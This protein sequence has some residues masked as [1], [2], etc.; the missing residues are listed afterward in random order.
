MI[1]KLTFILFFICSFAQSQMLIDIHKFAAA[2]NPELYTVGNAIATGANEANGITGLSFYQTTGQA[3]VS[4]SP[5]PQDGS[6]VL[7]FSETSAPDFAYENLTLD[8]ST[9]YEIGYWAWSDTS[10]GGRSQIWEGFT[11][12]PDFYYTTTPTYYE[13]TLTTNASSQILRWY[14]TITSAWV[15]IDGLSIKEQ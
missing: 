13:H 9:T 11:T 2:G 3:S 14:V 4:S 12:S 1:K 5:S 15:Y 7:K 8:N 6:Y 10:N